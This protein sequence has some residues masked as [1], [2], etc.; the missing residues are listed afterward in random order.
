M[1]VSEAMTAVVV[2]IG[3]GHSLREAAVKMHENNVGAAVIVDGELPGPAIITERDLLRATGRGEDIDE[4]LVR[5]H[6]SAHLIYAE[7]DWQLERAAIE[8]TR[9][10]FRHVVVVDG[11]EVIGILSMRDIV[12]CWVGDGA[13]CE[14]PPGAAGAS[15]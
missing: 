9:G 4:E 10:G 1:L 14:V 15:D 11:P 7:G 13:T 12:R 5:D 2:T 3:L 8:M 6:L